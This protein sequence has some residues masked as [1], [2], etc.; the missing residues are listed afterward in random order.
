MKKVALIPVIIGFSLA[1]CAQS[2]LQADY[3][4][5]VQLM[6]ENQVYDPTT[7]TR[8]S[9]TA[10]NGA[11]PDMLNLAVTTMR[12]QAADRKEVSKPIVLSI[13]GQGGQ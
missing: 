12:T 5:S 6:N 1:G 13:G 4:R 7:L 10:V 8:P 9:L 11:D 2:A 3:G